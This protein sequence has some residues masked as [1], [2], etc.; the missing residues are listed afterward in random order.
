MTPKSDVT[1]FSAAFLDQS[2]EITRQI[3][4]SKIELAAQILANVKENGGRLFIVGSGGGAA[5]ASHAVNDFRK[6][7]GLESYTP[8]DNVAELTARINDD[9]WDTSYSNWL[10]GSKMGPADALMVFSVGGGN[11]KHQVSVNL[12]NCIKHAR[13]VDAKV[14]GIVGRNG[15]FTLEK[16]DACVVIPPLFEQTV[17]AH[18]EAFQAVVWHLLVSHPLLQPNEPKWESIS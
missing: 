14:L 7:V 5:H 12:V 15:G 6:I 9:G 18:T 1:N 10:A 4:T 17:T 11:L 8:T 16:S 2:I 13:K 3:E